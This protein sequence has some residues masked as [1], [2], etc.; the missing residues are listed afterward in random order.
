MTDNHEIVPV[1]AAVSQNEIVVL[2]PSHPLMSRFQVALKKQLSTQKEKLDQELREANDSLRRFKQEREDVGVLLYG[3]QQEL[4]KQQT[5]LEI[6]S[7]VLSDKKQSRETAE[8]DLGAQR[9][10]FEHA[11]EEYSGFENLVVFGLKSV[12]LSGNRFF[13]LESVFLV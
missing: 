12:F 1:G 8:G 9:Q 5:E 7:D 4:A 3:A 10:V 13:G 11:N 2:D 6:C